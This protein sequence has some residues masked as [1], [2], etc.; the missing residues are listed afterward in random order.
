MSLKNSGLTLVDGYLSAVDT[1]AVE[2]V[3]AIATGSLI[4]VMER[5]EEGFYRP[6]AITKEDLET[7][8]VSGAKIKTTHLS[9]GVTPI[10]G[11]AYP[12][13]TM[14]IEY[15]DGV[16]QDAGRFDIDTEGGTSLDVVRT[17][18]VAN[19]ATLTVNMRNQTP[20]VYEYFLNGAGG[21]LTLQNVTGRNKFFNALLRLIADGSSRSFSIPATYP[22]Q[23]LRQ[24]PDGSTSIEVPAG[25][26]VEILI[27]SSTDGAVLIEA[28]S[29]SS[30][31]RGTKSQ[32]RTNLIGRA[33]DVYISP[34]N[35]V[36]VY[37]PSSNAADDDD[38]VIVHTPSGSRYLKQI[39]AKDLKTATFTSVASAKTSTIL[40]ESFEVNRDGLLILYRY[41]PGSPASGNDLDII[42]R[43]DGRR[44]FS[45]NFL[46]LETGVITTRFPPG[47]IRR[48]GALGI[49]ISS[50]VVDTAAIQVAVANA[51]AGA[52]KSIYIPAT[53]QFFAYEGQGEL[54]PDNVEVYGDGPSSHIR[55]VNPDVGTWYR[56][57]IFY[58]CTYGP[59]NTVSIQKAPKYNIGDAT[60]SA[61]SVTL[62]T[63]GDAANL[64]VG[65]VIVLGA[66]PFDK[67]GDSNKIRYAYQETNEV[68]K[69]V[70]AV[71]SLKYA[72][73]VDLAT[74]GA[75]SPVIV[76]VNS[77]TTTNS[78]GYTDRISKH[79]HIHDLRLSQAQTNEV[80]NAA[81]VGIPSHVMQ[82]GYGFESHLHNLMIED[83]AGIAGNLQCRN[84]IHDIKLSCYRQI[85]DFGYGSHHTTLYN[86][87][88]ELLSNPASNDAESLIFMSEASHDLELRNITAKGDWDGTNVFNIGNGAKR[89]K[90]SNVDIDLP[91][92][93][94]NAHGITITDDSDAVF[95]KDIQMSNVKINCLELGRLIRITG[96]SALASSVDRN[97]ILKDIEFNCAIG[98]TYS[99]SVFV[100]NIQQVTFD[101]WIVPTS[102]EI[103]L[104]NVRKGAFRRIFAGL[105]P[106][107]PNSTT[108]ANTEF[109]NSIF[110]S[111]IG[112]SLATFT[113]LL[114][115]TEMNFQ[116]AMSVKGQL[117]LNGERIVSSGSSTSCPNASA[118]QFRAASALKVGTYLVTLRSTDAATY[119]SGVVT[120]HGNATI[121]SVAIT[122]LVA[123]AGTVTADG[124]FN[125]LYTNSSG[126]TKTVLWSFLKIS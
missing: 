54:L 65:D 59:T 71:I 100:N 46:P 60:S 37:S 44:Y 95:S 117:N 104:T 97:F 2:E 126:A 112:S 53:T 12:Q 94:T 119:W 74:D 50:R 110:A 3:T 15:F 16:F 124:S 79:I 8:L 102:K 11:V 86:I 10:G 4:P 6:T 64:A 51:M 48:Y 38:L 9:D 40:L 99:D 39:P 82:L 122:Q 57:V 109:T 17:E 118:T 89:L 23:N 107:N 103:T 35:E 28:L 85:V 78:L 43:L 84:R 19:G 113:S 13:Y 68:T 105:A 45:E 101:N 32:L 88:W 24:N 93:T 115:G 1:A 66:M 22:V 47:D 70:G 63:I 123:V 80:T 27:S 77:G 91:L 31:S 5:L 69:I 87:N 25:E 58:C 67:D 108:V 83:Y 34:D 30:T 114:L 62:D 14:I 49:G 21:T 92:H 125:L 111:N 106:L 76:D 42:E 26:K 20:E 18:V 56:G 41:V 96:Q 121:T 7:A 120:C 36:Y 75:N 55:H 81:L 72:L 73:S 116:G 29:V 90:C 52:I 61:T 98:A 33:S